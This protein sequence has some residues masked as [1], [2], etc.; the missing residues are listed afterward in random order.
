MLFALWANLH[1]GGLSAWECSACGVGVRPAREHPVATGPRRRPSG[2]PGHTGHPLRR[3]VCGGS[4]WRRSVSARADIT[5]W[6]PITNDAVSLALW[7]VAA[8]LIVVACRRKGWA[9]LPMLVPTVV[10]ERLAFRVVRL[11]GFFALT[12]SAPARAVL[13]GLRTAAASAVATAGG[14]DIVAVG[15]MCLA[16]IVATGVG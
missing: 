4:C 8:S 16:G 12:S 1:G 5:E 11:Q 13:C 3:R 10:L 2:A 7:A 6:Q 15:A 9:A 14:R